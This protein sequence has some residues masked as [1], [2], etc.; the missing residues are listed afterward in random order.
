MRERR[1]K[2]GKALLGEIEKKKPAV[3][4]ETGTII[5]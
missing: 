3:P 2:C 5:N 4:G 1:E